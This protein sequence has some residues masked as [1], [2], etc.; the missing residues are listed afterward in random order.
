MKLK[1][2]FVSMIILFIISY[3][4]NAQTSPSKE[5]LGFAYVDLEYVV[6]NYEKM[7]IIQNALEKEYATEQAIIDQKTT[8]LEALE[9]EYLLRKDSLSSDETQNMEEDIRKKTKDAIAYHQIK[10]EEL[11]KQKQNK[12]S[13]VMREIRQTVQEV[14]TQKGYTTVVRESDLAYADPRFNLT[15]SVLDILNKRYLSE[16]KTEQNKQIIN[17]TKENVTGGTKE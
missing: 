5:S 10:A 3:S 7:R 14:A 16:V 13:V 6:A 9:K 12:L 1:Y 17:A 11:E 2:V 4:V 8:Q 15:D